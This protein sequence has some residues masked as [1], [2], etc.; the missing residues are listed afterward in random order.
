MLWS[1]LRSRAWDR[2]TF[3]RQHPIGP[4]ILDFYCA[5]ARLAIEVDGRT[6]EAEH[7]PDSDARRDAWLREQGVVVVRVPARD[8]L[9]RPDDTA[10][11]IIRRALSMI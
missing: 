6:H 1:R 10:D 9:T 11:G 2:P 3:R 8:V 7:R 5:K 4:Y